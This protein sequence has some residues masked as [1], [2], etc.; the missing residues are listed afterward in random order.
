[1]ICSAKP[2]LSDPRIT[3][4]RPPVGVRRHL[5]PQSNNAPRQ[6][7]EVSPNGS[8]AFARTA[9]RA[10]L[11]ALV[12]DADPGTPFHALARKDQR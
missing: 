10:R 12:I 9:F 2:R 5:I 8:C 1:M 3:D 11:A 6:F 4:T 7:P